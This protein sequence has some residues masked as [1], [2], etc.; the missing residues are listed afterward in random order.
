[1]DY[2]WVDNYSSYALICGVVG[3]DT[4]LGGAGS[5]DISRHFLGSW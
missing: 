2:G 4:V 3:C 5:I 1:M